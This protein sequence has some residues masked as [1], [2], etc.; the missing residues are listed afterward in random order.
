MLFV[1]GRGVFM[2]RGTRKDLRKKKEK[3]M[4]EKLMDK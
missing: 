2:K 1:G 3:K 4:K